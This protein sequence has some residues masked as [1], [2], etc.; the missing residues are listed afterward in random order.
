M[1][2]GSRVTQPLLVRRFLA[3]ALH[4]RQM[5][6]TRLQHAVSER[7]GE[8]VEL[9][10][11]GLHGVRVVRAIR[12]EEHLYSSLERVEEFFVPKLQPRLVI[13]VDVADHIHVGGRTVR[14]IVV[15]GDGP[16][17]A[18]VDDEPVQ[19]AESDLGHA[20]HVRDARVV[21][22]RLPQTR[23]VAESNHEVAQTRE[24]FGRQIRPRAFHPVGG[25][26]LG[27]ALADVA[28]T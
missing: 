6:L 9:A 20:V 18:V 22:E 28:F 19:V 14:R 5:G 12:M 11:R 3:L 21:Q 4:L 25:V 15:P 2:F 17:A 10:Q 13:P 1:D 23:V 7:P 16:C 27:G 26:P 24:I 8:V